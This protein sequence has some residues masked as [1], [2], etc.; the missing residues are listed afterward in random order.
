VLLALVTI[1]EIVNLK[2]DI[3]STPFGTLHVIAGLLLIYPAFIAPGRAFR[4]LRWKT[5]GEEL[6]FHRGV[7]TRIET[8]VPFRRV[9]HVDVTQSALQRS[10]HVTSL[11][12][13]TAGTIDHSVVVP[14]LSRETAEAIRDEVRA[15]IAREAD[16]R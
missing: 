11:V 7:L 5:E 10:F 16:D 4:A 14:G 13:H 9:Q 2:A 12:L 6:H 3:L 15:V 8:I 1:P